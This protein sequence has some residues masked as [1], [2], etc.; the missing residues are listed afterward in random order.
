MKINRSDY[1]NYLLEAQSHSGLPIFFKFSLEEIDD[2]CKSMT[3]MTDIF[4]ND[5]ITIENWMDSSVNLA[6]I[7]VHNA[8]R[9]IN[10][11]LK[12]YDW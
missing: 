5:S 9:N 3:A 10:P 11:N 7:L 8:R 2:F 12:S 4:K 1:I 6:M